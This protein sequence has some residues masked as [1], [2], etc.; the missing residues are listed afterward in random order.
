MPATIEASGNTLK[1]SYLRFISDAAPGLLLILIAV[2][3]QRSGVS[4]LSLAGSG[5]ELK[6]LVAVVALLLAVPAGLVVNGASHLFLGGLQTWVNRLC[7]RVRTWPIYDTHRSS[8]TDD[9][10]RCFEVE[11]EHWPLVGERV[12]ELLLIYAPQVAETLDHVRALKKFLRAAAL[13][14]LCGFIWQLATERNAAAWLLL[15]GAC[16]AVI[17]GGYITSYQQ[18]SGMMRAYILCGSPAAPLTISFIEHQQRL[19]NYAKEGNSSSGSDLRA[20]CVD[21]GRMETDEK[22]G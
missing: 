12:D 13:L 18:A 11:K 6:A 16:G 10:S 20:G 2:S 9:W 14:M 19:M 4:L 7:F 22:R 5:N 3:L 21:V 1:I 8:L 17:L 15:V